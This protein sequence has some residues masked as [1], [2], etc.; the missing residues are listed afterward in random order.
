V[1]LIVLPPTYER[2]VRIVKPARPGEWEAWQSIVIGIARGLLGRRFEAFVC[3]RYRNTQD[4]V[5]LASARSFDGIAEQL[6]KK[7]GVPETSLSEARS[8]L[9][10]VG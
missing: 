8:A 9:E 6:A 3:P 5:P 7:L 4:A 10:S 1:H 2:L